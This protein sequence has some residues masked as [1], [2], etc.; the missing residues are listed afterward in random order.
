[1]DSDQEAAA[2]EAADRQGKRPQLAPLPTAIVVAASCYL[3]LHLFAGLINASE[4]DYWTADILTIA[5]AAGAA[6]IQWW[7]ERAWLDRYSAARLQEFGPR[8]A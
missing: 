4:E 5:L 6:G 3:L 2:R 1:M 8:Q 7:R